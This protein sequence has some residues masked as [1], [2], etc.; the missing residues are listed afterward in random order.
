MH[1]APEWLVEVENPDVAGR[2]TRRGN[3][4]VRQWT[5]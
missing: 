4:R 5:L 3:H 2:R 1:E